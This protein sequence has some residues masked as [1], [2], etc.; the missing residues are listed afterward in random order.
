[1][2]ETAMN[3]EEIFCLHDAASRYIRPPLLCCSSS[4]SWHQHSAQSF[5]ENNT[6]FKSYITQSSTN[7]LKPLSPSRF[8]Y[9]TCPQPTLPP[10]STSNA[11]TA[12]TSWNVL[13]PGFDQVNALKSLSYHCRNASI[14]WITAP[15]VSPGTRRTRGLSRAV[16]QGKVWA[17]GKGGVRVFGGWLDC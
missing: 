17:L 7:F 16:M 14:T 9:S 11:A 4:I 1:M 13:L 5:S 10:W 2:F 3:I 12:E 8:T 6:S 15:C